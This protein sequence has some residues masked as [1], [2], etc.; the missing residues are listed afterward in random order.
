[1]ALI[2]FNYTWND[3]N[4]INT[5]SNSTSFRCGGFLVDRRS[6]VTAAHC[7]ATSNSLYDLVPNSYYSTIESCYTVYLG[8]HN[9]SDLNGT[10]VKKVKKIIK[11]RFLLFTLNFL[12][13]KF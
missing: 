2:E 3:N 7:I 1:M 12:L 6:V 11:V 5:A 9:K 8:L 4:T 10:S 13:L